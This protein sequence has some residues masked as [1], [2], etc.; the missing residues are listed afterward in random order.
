MSTLTALARVQAVAAGVAQPIATVRHVHVAHH[1]LVF[2]PL[3]LAGEA[4]APLAAMIGTDPT[5]PRLLVVPEPRNRDERFAFAADLATD[6]LSYIDGHCRET[7]VVERGP[8]GEPRPCYRDAPQVWVPN[9]EGIAFVRLLGRFTRFRRAEGP[10]AVHP[11]V[12]LLG[13]WLTFLADRAEFPGSSLLVAMTEALALHWATGQS[14]TEDRNLAALLGWIDPPPGLSGAQAAALAEDPAIWPPAGP[15]TDP[16]FDNARLAPA[17]AAY[18]EAPDEP[19]RRQAYA[20]LAELLR[21]QLA[22]TWELMWRGLALLRR[23]AP[24]A[25]VP[26]R[27][28]ADRMAFTEF[29]DSVRTGQARPQP[30]R[31][32]AVAAARRLHRLER[33]QAAYVVQRAY[34]D[35]LVMAEYRLTG[36]AFAGTVTHAEPNRVSDSGKKRVLRPRIVVV[37]EDW[38]PLP[39]GTVVYS[40]A[41]PSQ[42]ATVVRLHRT[43]ATTEVE[44]ELA[45]GMGRSLTPPP[46]S[47]PAVGEWVTYTTLA[48]EYR[49][50]ATFPAPE[51]TPWTHGGPSD[52]EPEEDAAEDWAR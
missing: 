3:T 52:G 38:M 12:P 44:L 21:S 31:D 32:G 15:R 28:A 5:A 29:A 35:P 22:P 34:D 45:G 49:P 43:D 6:F 42:R 10:H 1:P 19:A 30:R 33:A 37:T 25:H 4:N 50:E 39:L 48:H 24:G 7:E 41:R 40:P 8:G 18:H 9:R 27:W 16:E 23:L 17:I 51:E 46:G 14:A 20:V 11:S 47:V 36:E 13:Q 26:D 2:I